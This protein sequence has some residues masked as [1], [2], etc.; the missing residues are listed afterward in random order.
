ML[1]AS[2]FEDAQDPSAHLDT[3]VSSMFHVLMCLFEEEDTDNDT[4][5][6]DDGADEVGK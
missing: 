6:E 3:D 1:L 4:T 2:P 5:R